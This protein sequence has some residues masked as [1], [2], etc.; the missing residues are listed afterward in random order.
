MPIKNI[1]LDLGG[2]LLNLSFAKTEAAFK[3]IGLPDFNDHFSQFKASP[4]FEE[5]ETGRVGKEEF[6]RQ[7]KKETGLDRSDE[8]ITAAWNAMLLDFPAERIEWLE[9]LGK[10]YRVFLYS[11]TNA[12]HHDA[13][14]ESFIQVYP[15]RPFDSY[16]EKA[17]YSHL[18]GKRKP[19]PES[20][21]DLLID[22]GLLAE[23]TVFI[24][25]TLPNIEGARVAGLQVHHLT[26]NLTELK[27]D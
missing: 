1:L 13:F 26:G 14:Q 23:E 19:Y 7:F 22:A 5:L 10:R 27:W 4:L 8:E 2:V 21:T 24:D 25:D 6:L 17:Y 9:K 3:N 12:F 11:N 16:F 20:Y 15:G 18:F